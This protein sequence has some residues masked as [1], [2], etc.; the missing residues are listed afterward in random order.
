MEVKITFDPQTHQL[1]VTTPPDNVLALGMIA[2]AQAYVFSKFKWNED[3]PKHI[4][5]FR[6]PIPPAPSGPQ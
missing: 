2:V 5:P 1:N 3:P 6:G 4:L